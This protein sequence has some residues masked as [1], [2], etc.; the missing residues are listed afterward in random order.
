[1]LIIV[2]LALVLAFCGVILYFFN[3]AFARKFSVSAADMDE[4]LGKELS[5]YSEVI[6][7]GREFMKNQPHEW[8]Y[9]N[10][11]DG[12][13]LAARY[14]DNNSTCTILLFHG[15]RSSAVHD[16]SCAVEMYYK[17]GFNILLADQ[18]AHGKSE[19]KYITF[20]VN[21]SRDVLTW[22]E[23]VNQ[24]FAPKQVIISGIS[25][26]ATTVLLSLR[27]PLPQNVKGVIA[28]CGFTSP[29]EIIAKVG[30]DSFKI[31]AKP[32]IPFLN[33]ACKFLG[34][35]SIT[36]LSTVDTVK[37]TDLPIMFIHGEKD[38]F[39]PCEMTKTTFKNCKENCRMFLSREAG[40]GTSF[41]L[42]TEPL[43]NELKSFLNL[44]IEDL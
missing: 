43:I 15:Y 36:E 34:K 41:L 5:P 31:N 35:F 9:T 17:M 23:F 10:S 27:L 28:D 29:A 22:V 7:K 11:F 32:L 1:L 18:R 14:Y 44:C 24:H 8:Y 19:G 38:T 13:K 39:V 40:H 6:G 42:D 4:N 20:G 12:L 16:F 37:N 3:L 21:E 2:I 30:K 33:L 25:M 26:G